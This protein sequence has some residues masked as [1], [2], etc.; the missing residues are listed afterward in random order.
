[1]V[2]VVVGEEEEED[3]EEESRFWLRTCK[4]PCCFCWRLLSRRRIWPRAVR[5]DDDG[6]DNG[7]SGVDAGERSVVVGE[8]GVMASDVGGAGPM[9]VPRLRRPGACDVVS[10]CPACWS[11]SAV[12]AAI[13]LETVPDWAPT[14]VAFGDRRT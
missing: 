11:S 9:T 12:V 1:M 6:L 4:L 3:D 5:G 8:R 13:C 7:V 10:F 2:V 14:D